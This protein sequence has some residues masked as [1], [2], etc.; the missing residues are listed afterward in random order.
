[1]G[2]ERKGLIIILQ[3][4]IEHK[5]EL[6]CCVLVGDANN[7]RLGL[8]GPGAVETPDDVSSGLVAGPRAAGGAPSRPEQQTVRASRPG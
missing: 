8:T 5:A 3:D 6:L 7:C 1:M 2:N 4:G